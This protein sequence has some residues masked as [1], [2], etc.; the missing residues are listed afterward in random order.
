MFEER[1]ITVGQIKDRR[2]VVAV[3]LYFDDNDEEVIRIILARKATV[4]ER[5]QYEK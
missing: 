4:N 1:W 2:V 3:N 5:M